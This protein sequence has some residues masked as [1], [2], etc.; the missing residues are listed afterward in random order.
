MRGRWERSDA[1]Q[2]LIDPT[3]RRAANRSRPWQDAGAV[4]SDIG[5]VFGRGAQ[6]REQSERYPSDQACHRGF[7]PWV[8]ECKLQRLRCVLGEL[9][10]GGG[11]PGVIDA[12]FPGAR[13]RARPLN[14]PSTMKGRWSSFSPFLSKALRRTKAN[15]SKASPDVASSTA[16][17]RDRS[18]GRP[19]TATAW[20]E[21]RHRSAA[22]RPS[23]LIA[24]GAAPRRRTVVA[25]VATKDVGEWNDRLPGCIIFCRADDRPVDHSEAF[26]DKVRPRLLVNPFG[27]L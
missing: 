23:N 3:L 5:W 14:V 9:P 4:V 18:A 8:R 12:S 20:I 15:L 19:M 1:Q 7:Q 25:C 2:Q 26:F 17:R 24:A 6:G 22:S 13:K 16:S 21:V 10:A 27:Y 11:L